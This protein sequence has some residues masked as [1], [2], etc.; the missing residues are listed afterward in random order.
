MKQDKNRVLEAKKKKLYIEAKIY[1]LRAVL[2][3][4][5]DLRKKSLKCLE[6]LNELNKL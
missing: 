1:S 5:E 2:E 4:S 3:T 6:K